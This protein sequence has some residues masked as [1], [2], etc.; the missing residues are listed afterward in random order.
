MEFNLAPEIAEK[1]RLDS[2]LRQADKERRLK[3]IPFDW[4]DLPRIDWPYGNAHPKEFKGWKIVQ[5]DGRELIVETLHQENIYAD[6]LLGGL[7]YPTDYLL[8]SIARAEALY[9]YEKSSPIIL[10]PSLYWGRKIM[11]VDGE[12]KGYEWMTLPRV[13]CIAELFC[14][15]PV[16]EKDQPLSS[17]IVIWF[18]DQFG[19]PDEQVQAQLQTIDWKKQGSDCTP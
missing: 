11:M 12:D 15:K 10:P 7:H 1:M 14:A 6:S 18:Q 19:L 8:E 16:R 2:A 3:L 9:P 13:R 17:A 4:K 5:S